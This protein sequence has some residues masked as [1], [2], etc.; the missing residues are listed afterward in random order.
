MEVFTLNCW[1]RGS[2]AGEIFHV[3]ISKTEDVA[4]LKEAIK[5]EAPVTFREVDAHTLHLYK[6]RNPLPRPYEDNLSKIILSEDGELLE[7]VDKLSEVFPEQPP[8]R[9]IHIIVDAPYL[10]IDCWLRGR[11]FD[12][13]FEISTRA[14]AT[15]SQLKDRVREAKPMLKNVDSDYIRLYRISGDDDEIRQSLNRIGDGNPFHGPLLPIFLGM[16]VLDPF[17]VVAEVTSSTTGKHV[18]EAADEWIVDRVKRSKIA[19]ESPSILALPQVYRDWKRDPE[20]CILDHCRLSD[21][22]G[23]LY[24]PPISIQYEGFGHFLDIFRGKKDVPG[25]QHVSSAALLLAVDHFAEEMSLVYPD[26]LSRRDKGLTALTDIFRARTE[27]PHWMLVAK[28]VSGKAT[29]DGV[30]CGPH[31]AA[32]CVADFKNELANVTGIPYVEMTSY[33]AHSVGESIKHAAPALLIR[34]WNFPCLG[35]TIVGHYVTFYAV[36]YFGEWRVVALTP[37]LSCIRASGDGD[38]RIA[39]YNAFTAASVLIAHIHDRASMEMACDPTLHIQ[40]NRRE[41]PPI[42]SLKSPFS[43]TRIEFEILAPFPGTVVPGRHL[44]TAKRTGGDYKEEI[45]V[46]FARRYS[47]ELHMFCAKQRRAPAL[48]GFERLPGGF[49]GIAMELVQSV[50][51]HDEKCRDLGKQLKAL[52]TSF[53]NE[54]LVHGDL[55]SPNIVCNDQGVMVVDF[56]WGGKL[57]EASYPISQLNPDLT[58][59]RD[60]ADLKITNDDD[61]RV[62]NKTLKYLEWE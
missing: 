14:N 9:H 29:S 30:I 62:L 2:D 46:K 61:M 32:S 40:E 60:S 12:T 55:R 52:V 43:D 21:S 20:E 31:L 22:P 34:Q 26:E 17:L 39:L 45:I 35:L 56:D 23:E 1:I 58:E 36:I 19:T 47:D 18:L 28:S 16:P 48:L 33:F 15:T 54:G 10:M 4:T 42:S 53:H 13:R 51:P 5:N 38:D 57:G 49:F 50:S 27:D 37:G 59:G 44:Y 7:M 11:T 8:K 25:I 3:K 41:L 6:P 24:L